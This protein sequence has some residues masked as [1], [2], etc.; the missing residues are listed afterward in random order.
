MKT[1]RRLFAANL[2]S[3]LRDRMALFWFLAFP[4]LFTLL[5]GFIFSGNG[6][7]AYK[8][9]LA[10]PKG[11]V[12]AEGLAAGFKSIKAFKITRGPLKTELAAL[13]KG[14]RDLVVEIPAG[15]ALDVGSGRQVEIPVL[16]DAGREQTPDGCSFPSSPRC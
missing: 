5:L 4:V 6:E 12:L 11:D 9:G 14:D 1:F 2:K 3:L 8:I 7:A 13:K 15:A 16:Y 10:A